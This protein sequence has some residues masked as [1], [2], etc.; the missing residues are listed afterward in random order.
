MRSMPALGFDRKS[1]AG[2]FSHGDYLR[3]GDMA[4]PFAD[5]AR[6]DGQ[7]AAKVPPVL[8]ICNGFQTFPRTTWPHAGRSE[9]N[10]SLALHHAA[11]ASRRNK[12]QHRPITGCYRLLRRG[13][14]LRSDRARRRQLLRRYRDARPARGRRPSRACA[15]PMLRATCLQRRAR[16]ARS[17]TTRE[18]AI[19]RAAFSG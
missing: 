7:R 15:T 13:H 18:S 8:G 17:A 4:G 3:C 1:C 2:G 14:C 19:R 11:S 6:R 16:T 10:K 5:H 12:L 9:G